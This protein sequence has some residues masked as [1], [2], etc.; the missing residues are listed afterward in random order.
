MLIFLNIINILLI[1]CNINFKFID[2]FVLFYVKKK[3]LIN[4]TLNKLEF[5]KKKK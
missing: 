5:I 1:I 4:N 2:F 3:S